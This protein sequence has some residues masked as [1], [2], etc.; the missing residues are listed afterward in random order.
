MYDNNLNSFENNNENQEP[1]TEEQNL[2]E[3]TENTGFVLVGL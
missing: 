2:T 3:Q 1:V